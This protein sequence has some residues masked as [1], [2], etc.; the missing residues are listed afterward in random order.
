MAEITASDKNPLARI[1]SH[2]NLR[3]LC[4][5]LASILVCSVF[6][7]VFGQS[8]SSVQSL[9]ENQRK[10]ELSRSQLKSS[11]P[12]V[13]RD[14]V[15][16]LGR[17]KSDEASRIAAIAL[18]DA[19]PRVRASAVE[20]VLSKPASE[21]V[22]DLTPLLADKN[23]F[24]RQEAAYALGRTHSK[25]ATSALV[26]VLRFDKNSGARGAA[27]ISLGII[28]DNSATPALLAVV[29]GQ[30]VNEGK[31]KQKPEKNEFV[32]REIF[33][34]LGKVRDPAALPILRSTL[35]NV[36]APSV[37]RQMAAQALGEL[38]DQDSRPTLT[39]LLT[40]A[41]PYL[42]AAARDAIRRLDTK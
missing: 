31:R 22:T 10:L 2:F 34:T 4:C 7:A 36:A 3:F 41:D 30:A 35:E 1:E 21:A 37:L 40:A 9:T 17:M 29:N 28:G 42:A 26:E 6:G 24:V 19:D 18:K 13:R 5:A 11:D 39:A 20:A 12:E 16:Y 32:L 27:A 38:K 15:L 25:D 33:N 8:P 23:E 14:A